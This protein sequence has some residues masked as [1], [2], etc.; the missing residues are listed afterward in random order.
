[1]SDNQITLNPN[2]ASTL[3]F[4]VMISGLEKIK[5]TVR[6]VLKNMMEGLDWSVNCSNI[7]GT[8]WQA[9]F[10]KLG[11]T[12]DSCSFAVEVMIDEFFFVPATGEITFV[13]ASNVTFDK[14]KGNKPSVSASFTVKQEED[15]KP[16]PKRKVKEGAEAANITGRYAPTNDLLK[17]EFPP[18][19]SHA[20]TPKLDPMDEFID[21]DEL[22]GEVTPGPGEPY[23]EK[24]EEDEE[25]DDDFLDK[26]IDESTQ[27]IINNIFGR[28]V[29]LGVSHRGN[30]TRGSLFKRDANGKAIVPGLETKEQKLKIAENSRKV[31]DMLK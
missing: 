11:I 9:S 3:E 16:K 4:D 14:T 15:I 1:M 27:S 22:F 18:E 5:P 29:Q 2:K 17:P 20:K 7:E 30:G 6:F 10:P 26:D 24:Y 31:K 19:E 23:P 13:N 12:Q 21:K 28:P 8:K 25:L